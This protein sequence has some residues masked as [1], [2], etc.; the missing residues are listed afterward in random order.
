[1]V[2][3]ICPDGAHIAQILPEIR[4]VLPE[5]P[6]LPDDD[7][8]RARFALFDAFSRLLRAAA[9][10]GPLIVIFDDLHAADEPS[11]LL[12]RFVAMDLADSSLLIVAI[13]REG[14]LA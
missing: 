6:V 11:L 2:R 4:S 12:L 1:L 3:R 14:E 8:D 9:R 5:L 13:Y 7:S 10:D